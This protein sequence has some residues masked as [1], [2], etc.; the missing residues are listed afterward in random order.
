M[1]VG[2]ILGYSGLSKNMRNN[3]SKMSKIVHKAYVIIFFVLPLCIL[4]FLPQSRFDYQLWILIIGIIL[5][6]IGITIEVFAFYKIGIIPGGKAGK[7]IIN[8]GIYSLVRHPIYLSTIL[9]SIGIDLI[10][11]AQYALIYVPIFIILSIIL[12]L[13]EEKGLIEDFGEKYLEYKNK[14]KWRLFPYLF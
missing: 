10:L 3:F 5:T 6:G 11:R 1:W 7:D 12:T 14:T 9:W 4:P 8:A 2:F 13:T